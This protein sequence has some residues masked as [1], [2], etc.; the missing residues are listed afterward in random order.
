VF[1]FEA[2]D[3]TVQTPRLNET[4]G[5]VVAPT[6]DALTQLQRGGQRG[7]YLVTWLPDAEAIGSAGFGL[8]NELDGRG[9]DVRAE[10]AFRPGATRYHVI[11]ARKPALEIHLAT[12]PDIANW[13]RDSRFVQVAFFDPRSA[14]ERR[15]FDRLHAR[16]AAE[17]RGAGLGNRVAQ[18][19]DNLFMLALAPHVPVSTQRLI[20]Q[21]LDL[22]MPMAVFIG[23]P[24]NG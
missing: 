14:T 8:L 21:M 10:E 15:E 7:P 24:D 1:A 2:S 19:D 5:A 23:P 16:V 11:D 9:F 6:A 22:S 13:Q 20:T 4:L 17:L 18:I 12:G 3:V